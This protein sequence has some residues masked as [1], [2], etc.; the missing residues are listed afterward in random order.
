VDGKSPPCVARR[1]CSFSWLPWVRLIADGR[2][3]RLTAIGLGGL[4]L[5]PLPA[6]HYQPQTADDR[7]LDERQVAET[8]G[9]ELMRE[10]KR[11]Q[12]GK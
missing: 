8:D 9:W 6:L 7:L 1:A 12:P 3:H 10:A 11:D 5:P 4:L 2:P